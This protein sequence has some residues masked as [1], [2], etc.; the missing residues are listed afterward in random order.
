[1]WEHTWKFSCHPD[2]DSVN[3]PHCWKNTPLRNTLQTA[4]PKKINNSR[5]WTQSLDPERHLGYFL[6]NIKMMSPNISYF[7]FIVCIC[8][9]RIFIFMQIYSKPF[10][11]KWPDKLIQSHSLLK[12]CSQTFRVSAIKKNAIN[13]MWFYRHKDIFVKKKWGSSVAMEATPSY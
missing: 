13:H 7:S 1:M 6:E 5:A 3:Q 8:E 10:C 4:Q 11:K 12:N 2:T 9:G